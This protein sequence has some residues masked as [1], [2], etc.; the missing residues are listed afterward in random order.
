MDEICFVIVYGKHNKYT[1]NILVAAL[2]AYNKTVKVYMTR[3]DNDIVQDFLRIKNKCRKTVIGFTFMTT[4]IETVLRVLPQIKQTL[5]NALFVAG[6][7]HASGDPLGTLTKLGFNLVVYGEGEAT[8]IDLIKAVENN[9]DERICG[10]AYME[11]EKLVIKKRSHIDLDIYPPFPYWRDLFNPIEIMRGCNASC[12]FCQVAYMFG[13]PR[14]RSIDVII[15]YSK[16]MMEHDLKDLRFI[17]PN[18]FGYGSKDGIK[19][20][21]EKILELLYRLRELANKYKGRIFFGT[22]PSEVRPDSVEEELVK[23]IRKVVDNKRIIVGAQSGSNKILSKIH[24]NHNADTIIN[25][26]EILMRNKFEVDVDIIVGF[27]FEE[28]EDV[29]E[30]INLINKLKKYGARI[31]LHTFIPLPGTPLFSLSSISINENTKRYLFKL[32]GEGKAYGDWLEQEKLARLII[33]FRDRGIIYDINRYA[34]RLKIIE[35]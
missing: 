30:T 21:T 10:I 17:A 12:Y 25:A 6:G 33:T 1:A 14:Y 2:E 7:P 16:I 34:N 32:V 8:L 29:E 19:P 24:R 9:E 20:S 22:F 18:S 15:Q 27:E 5:P 3:F 23:S 31:H 13:L 4:Q 35:C 11:D 28:H 26:V